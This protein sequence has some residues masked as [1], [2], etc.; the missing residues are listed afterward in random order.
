LPGG[1]RGQGAAQAVIAVL[2]SYRGRAPVQP[3][4][5]PLAAVNSL[6]VQVPRVSLCGGDL[7]VERVWVGL[8]V[9]D[10]VEVLAVDVGGRCAV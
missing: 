1:C 3:G 5:R 9:F 8:L 7:L 10:S 4:L 2:L 6:A